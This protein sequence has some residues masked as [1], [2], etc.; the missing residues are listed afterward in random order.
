MDNLFKVPLFSAPISPKM[1]ATPSPPLQSQ[2]LPPPVHAN[3]KIF[4]F[5]MQQHSGEFNSNMVDANPIRSPPPGFSFPAA[6]AGIPKPAPTPPVVAEQLRHQKTADEIKLAAL[7]QAIAAAKQRELE[8]LELQK[9]KMEQAERVRRQRLIEQKQAKEQQQRQQKAVEEAAAAAA[10]AAEVQDQ[11][12][13]RREEKR[14]T[15]CNQLL[16]ELIDHQLEGLCQ[17]EWS[18]FQN[19]L[20]IY[21]SLLDQEIVDLVKRNM[22]RADYELGLMRHY[23]RRWRNYRGVQQHKD[24]LFDCLPLSFGGES[25]HKLLNINTAEQPLRMLRRYRQGEACDYRQLLAGMDDQ[26]WLKLDL[27]EL[28][29]RAMQH[30][31]FTP[32]SRHFFKLLLSLPDSSAGVVMEHALDRGLLQQPMQLDGEHSEAGDAYISG[33]SHGVALCVHKLKGLTEPNAKQLNNAD[34]IVCFVDAKQ[35][36]EARQ[37]LHSLIQSSG[38]DYVAVVVQQQETQQSLLVEQLELEAVSA[39]RIFDCRTMAR[40]KQKLQLVALLQCAVQ[41]LANQPHRSRGALQQV[42]LREWLLC[43]LGDEL[44]KRLRHAAQLDATIGW[45]SRQSP[46]YCAQLYNEA[47][48]RLQLLA[49]EDLGDRPQL[50]QELRAYVEPLQPQASLPNRLEYFVKGWQTREERLKIVQLLEQVKLPE[51]MPLPTKKGESQREICEWL[52]NYAQVSQQESIVETVALRAIQTLEVQLRSGL[53]NY[54]DIVE[55]F[56]KE[57]LHFLL[58]RNV[59][60]LPA[61]IVFRRHTMQRCFET[62]WYYDWQSPEEPAVTVDEQQQGLAKAVPIVPP[63]PE[64]ISFEHVMRKA[65]AALDKSQLQRIERKT[66]TVLNEPLDRLERT[67]QRCDGQTMAALQEQHQQRQSENMPTPQVKRQRLS[68]PADEGSTML[69]HTERLLTVSQTSEERR[70]QVLQRAN[71]FL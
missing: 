44:Y 66:L 41:F 21:E 20:H 13:R 45:R 1:K 63:P 52:L 42:E 53:P 16:N 24:A 6:A 26:C 51:M 58:H 5:D 71:K 64:P 39:Y 31:H 55:I 43:H 14:E 34:G 56:S 4:G 48:R 29:S 2:Q 3:N 10:A 38:C 25:S 65:Q 61:A 69:D 68:T 8:L 11:R 22:L 23:W 37:R 57:R 19:V 15:K 67:M 30:Q 9:T 46:Q 27:W 40:G 33:L 12:L 7:Q 62:H 49:A 32:G 18:L 59:A 70:I 47:V 28:L 54:L 36:L 35:L 60:S 17:Q 50:P